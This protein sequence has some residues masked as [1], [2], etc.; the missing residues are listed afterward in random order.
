MGQYK[1]LGSRH[2]VRHWGCPC[3]E[4]RIAMAGH[5]R[6]YY[7]LTGDRRLEDIFEELK[8]NEQTFFNRDPLGDFFEKEQMVYP[9]HARSGPDW[10]ALCSNWMM[11]WER[12]GDT[13]YRDK[14]L[15]GMQDIKAAPLKLISGPDFEFDPANVHL[16]YIGERATGGTHL[17]I[18][19][20]APQIWMEMADLLDDAQWK[21]MMAEYGRFYYLPRE[22]QLKESDNIIGNRE[23][24]LPFMAA[25]MAAYGAVY[26]KDEVLASRTWRYLL[27]AM[28]HEGNHQGFQTV[29]VADGGNQQLLQEIPW[30]ST[31]FVAQWCLNV[32]VALRFIK[33]KLPKTL[34]EA[35]ALIEDMNQI[36]FR[37]A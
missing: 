16:R 34:E 15:T 35:D 28:M 32:I 9:S 11:E 3:K 20:G 12:T 33:G 2:N 10:S 7:F 36:T 24:S 23:F 18:C 19:M 29:T 4:A 21:Q 8:D 6:V 26:L 37:K 27:H 17:Q 31:N 30:I 5:H 13:K 22:E 25:A 14:I 1:G